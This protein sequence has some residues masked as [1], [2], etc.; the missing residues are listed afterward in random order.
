MRQLPTRDKR[1]MTIYILLVILFHSFPKYF[2]ILYAYIAY[3]VVL[4]NA[5][6]VLSFIFTRIHSKLYRS[7]LII[8]RVSDLEFCLKFSEF[9]T[10]IRIIN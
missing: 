7:S 10:A 2:K 8:V 9:G 4:R 5:I 6:M 3:Y 1:T